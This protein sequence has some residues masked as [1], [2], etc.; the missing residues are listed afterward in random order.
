[1][2]LARK[3]MGERLQVNDESMTLKFQITLVILMTSVI[4][5]GDEAPSPPSPNTETDTPSEKAPN[6]T[7][8]ELDYEVTTPETWTRLRQIQARRSPEFGLTTRFRDLENGDG[9]H[10]QAGLRHH[11]RED[12]SLIYRSQHSR[13]LGAN[14]SFDAQNLSLFHLSLLF[15]HGPSNWFGSLELGHQGKAGA[16]LSWERSLQSGAGFLIQLKRHSIHESHESLK[17][18][19]VVDEFR[20]G[21]S[22]TIPHQMF[23]NGQQSF[24][25]SR[26]HC[27]IP[28]KGHGRD[29]L[30]EWGINL[31]PV[32]QRTMGWQFF[33]RNL[34][35]PDEIRHQ[36]QFKVQHQIRSFDG[37]NSYFLQIQRTKDSRNSSAIARTSWPFSQHTGLEIQANIGQDLERG[38]K[39]GKIY[40]LQTR[41]LWVPTHLTRLELRINNSTENTGVVSGDILEF[42]ISWHVNL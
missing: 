40:G 37:E 12:L 14:G 7:K 25:K 19:E 4:Y 6:S 16:E 5:A 22:F 26:L 21:F 18:C 2:A 41:Y 24:F 36:L 29:S 28:S 8:K 9:F 42:G 13:Y 39:F 15:E 38:L 10:L 27:G 33:D 1:M 34:R 35:Y 17:Y 32:P 30:L 20:T 23:L 11:V 3:E 31:L